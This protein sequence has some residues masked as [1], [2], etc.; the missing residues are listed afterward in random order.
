MAADHA[1]LDTDNRSLTQKQ[2][3]WRNEGDIEMHRANLAGAKNTLWNRKR[4]A[5]ITQ[6]KIDK[7]KGG[8]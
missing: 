4:N 2:G 8:S 5:R 1:S 6:A 7:K 3:A